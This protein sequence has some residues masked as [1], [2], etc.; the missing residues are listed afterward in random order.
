MKK[1]VLIAVFF[2]LMLTGAASAESINISLD[3]VVN[4]LNVPVLFDSIGPMRI[5]NSTVV[6]LRRFCESA[7]FEVSWKDEN[8]TALITL[9]ANEKSALPV[10]R[11]AYNVIKKA[12]ARGLA[13]TPK[14]ISASLTANR[15]EIALK[16]NY[17]DSEGD[18][19]S[20][21]KNVSSTVPT[22]IVGSGSIVVPLRSLM[23]LFGLWVNWNTSGITI[24]IPPFEA[25]QD[26]LEFVPSEDIVVIEANP[27]NWYAAIEEQAT[28]EEAFA[29]GG[30]VPEGAVYLGT[31][32]IS[33]YCTC[34]K[35]SG[36]YGS[37]TAWAGEVNPG[38]TIAVDPSVIPKLSSVYIDGYGTR[39]A[40]DCG[41]AIKGNRIDVAVNNHDE[42][43]ALGVVYKDVWQLP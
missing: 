8:K 3:N 39:R 27:D 38:V 28:A 1:K 18:I 30:S 34:A 26:E 4:D 6:P 7:G 22:T 16:Y 29:Q 12:D 15:S 42:A 36:S 23:E 37:A 21:G 20:L 19:I 17:T 11:Y 25:P 33:H 24:S 2:F 32:R 43:M 14:S 40:E 41:G 13:L 35:C 31:F 9:N 10:E 5:E